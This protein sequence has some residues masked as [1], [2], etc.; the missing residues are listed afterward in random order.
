MKICHVT[1]VHTQHDIRIFRKQ[2]VSLAKQG[3]D[4]TFLVAN[5]TIEEVQGVKIVPFELPT[6]SR[7]SRI[8][9][10]SKFAFKAALKQDADV[11]H[12]HDPELLPM[13]KKLIKAGKK[14]IFDAHEDFPAQIRDK[15]Y[16]PKMFRGVLAKIAES[17]E[18]RC[19][20]KL[21]AVV[22]ATPHIAKKFLNLNKHTLDINNYPISSELYGDLKP[23]VQE[24]QVCYVGGLTEIRG[25]EQLIDAMTHVNGVLTIAGKF[26]PQTFEE[27]VKSKKGFDRCKH[28]G[29]INRSEVRDLM[30]SSIAGIVTFLPCANHVEAQP[31]KIFEYMSAGLPVIASNFELW[32]DLSEKNNCGICVDPHNPEAIANAITYVIDNPE[33]ARAMGA[34]GRDLVTRVYN[35]EN[36]EQKLVAL[37][38]SIEQ[39][40]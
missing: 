38:K 10:A 5:G 36:E 25:V 29:L 9:K 17:Y 24:K 15:Y 21:T 20:P 8:R 23:N 33:E 31:N 37:Y 3:W 1:S 12:F 40:L 26:S 19:A 7:F 32:K 22:T 35:W 18:R 16:I 27:H 34:K 2:C 28:L 11:Y 14:A 39:K 13:G 4:V 6:S 30:A